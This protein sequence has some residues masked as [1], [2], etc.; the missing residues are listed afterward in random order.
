[1]DADRTQAPA[2]SVVAAANRLAP[3]M[4][5]V[6][7]LVIVAS[8]IVVFRLI[9]VG[10]AIQAMQAWIEG[11]GVAGPIVY[12]LVY[13]VAVVLLVPGSALTLAGGAIFGLAAGTITVSLAS[14]T[15]AALAFLVARYLARER[16]AER[17]KRYP[18]FHAIDRAISRGGWRIVALLRL[19]PAVPFNLQNYLYGLTGIRFWP[20]VLA[21]WV[22]MLPGTFLYV[23]FGYLAR[24]G[25]AAAAG[26]ASQRTL[27]WVLRAVGLLATIAVTVYVTRLAKR[28]IAERTEIAEPREPVVAPTSA[29]AP[30]PRGWPW[31]A[32]ISAAAAILFAAAAAYAHLHSKDV[33]RLFARYFGPPAVVLKEVYERR[34]AGPAFDHSAFDRVLKAHVSPEGWVDY[35][36]LRR[37]PSTLDAY[38]ASLAAAPFDAMDRDEKLVLLINAYNAFTLRLILDHQPLESIRDIPPDERWDARR[39]N[40]GGRVLSLNEIEHEEIRPKFAEPR[41]HFVLVCAAAGCPPLRQDA[42]RADRL[43]S[44]LEEQTRLVHADERWLRYDEKENA[45]HLTMLYHPTWYGGDF[46]QAAGSALQY[47]ARYSPALQRA[48][49]AGRQPAIRWIDYDWSLNDLEAAR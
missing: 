41:I 47:A 6:A 9:P 15:G 38:I 36:G 17:V 19:S 48:L 11:L 30:P 12:G 45:V 13:V 46:R 44:Q 32:T 5:I 39:W 23:Y 16:V 22:A 43:E 31:G 28:A 8:V 2:S 4:K 27:T 24:E 42:Y 40:V 49:E 35:E 26:G 10:Q 25:A 34:A 7:A 18:K 33:K 21:S 37:D 1:M 14:T 29:A 20:C 3:A